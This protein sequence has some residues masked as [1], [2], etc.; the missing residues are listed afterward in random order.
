MYNYDVILFIEFLKNHN[1]ILQNLKSEKDLDLEFIQNKVIPIAKENGF[2]IN[3][4]D[5]FSYLNECL[6][7]K[8]KLLDDSFL[9]GVA[10][11]KMNNKFIAYGLL[12]FMGVTG[13]SNHEIYAM[14]SGNPSSS[15]SI[16]KSETKKT[17][18]TIK[19]MSNNVLSQDELEYYQDK[20]GSAYRIVSSQGMSGSYSTAYNLEDNQGNRFILKISNNPQNNE[21]WV[22]KQRKTQEKIQ[23]Y[24]ADYEG[25]LK[26]PNY[27]KIGDDFVIEENLGEGLDLEILQNLNEQ[28]REK[29]TN[30]LAE[31]LSYTHKKEKGGVFSY[32]LGH[33]GVF[34]L[35][36]AY[37][38]LNDAGALNSDEQK[39]LTD[40]ISYFEKRD[41]SDEVTALT[42]TDIR[43]QNIVYNSKTKT[44]GLIDF[45]SLNTVAPIYY[46][47]TSGTVGSFGIPYDLCS[48]VIDRYNEISD[49]KVDK[50]KIKIFHKLGTMY[51][52]CTCAK[53]RDNRSKEEICTQTWKNGI[54]QRFEKIDIGFS[55][56]K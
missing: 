39:L 29:F 7:K 38:Y 12:T 13:L 52:F 8:D 30:G 18:K 36:D 2:N 17:I 32:K 37:N 47:F 55:N 24:Y 21:H 3:A 10:G 43:L 40:L 41:T 50:E 25:S 16:T 34:T 48:K 19:S 33:E 42:H 56:L 22:Q 27:I 4:K 1:G 20:I 26:I 53:F 11:G 14:H 5:I 23:K 45:E 54:K 51:E 31:F 9:E 28:E 15:I 44:F 46:D 49:I 6:S 35:K